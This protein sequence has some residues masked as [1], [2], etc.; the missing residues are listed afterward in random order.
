MTSDAVATVRDL[1]PAAVPAAT[2]YD[3]GAASDLRVP[4]SPRYPGGDACKTKESS[5]RSRF[6]IDRKTLSLL[7][8]DELLLKLLHKSVVFAFTQI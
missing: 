3:D 6:V 5:S 1:A 4:R 8:R 2:M 7:L